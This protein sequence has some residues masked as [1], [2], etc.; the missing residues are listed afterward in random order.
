MASPISSTDI[1]LSSPVLHRPIP[2]GEYIDSYFSNADTIKSIAWKMLKILDKL[3]QLKNRQIESVVLFNMTRD[4]FEISGNPGHYSI[5]IANQKYYKVFSTIGEKENLSRVAYIVH[6]L[7]HICEGPTPPELD[8]LIVKLSSSKYSVKDALRHPFFTGQIVGIKRPLSLTP[9][10]EKLSKLTKEH[11]ALVCASGELTCFFP[12]T[13]A[14]CCKILGG[15]GSS[16]V[17]SINAWRHGAKKTHEVAVKA[18]SY[19]SGFLYEKAVADDARAQ[20]PG[21]S[22][23]LPSFPID[24]FTF[25]R[26]TKEDFLLKHLSGLEQDRYFLVS[27]L[28]A[29]DLNTLLTNNDLGLRHIHLIAKDLFSQ[30]EKLYD[31]GIIH[32]DI[33]PGNVLVFTEKIADG[34]SS[35]LGVELCDFGISYS[36]RVRQEDYC[37]PDPPTT[38]HYRAFDLCDGIPTRNVTEIHD[39]KETFVK[40]KVLSRSADMWSVG[41]TLAELVTKSPIFPGSKDSRQLKEIKEVLGLQ[42]FSDPSSE[43]GTIKASLRNLFS[44]KGNTEIKKLIRECNT[45]VENLIDLITRCFATDPERRITAKE[46]LEHPFIKGL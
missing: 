18:F 16:T 5:T 32:Y 43:A 11:F 10:E 26:K 25:T 40:R 1:N 13:M 28:A 36:P 46:A 22:D 4:T 27:D 39:G 44:K 38:R 19:R 14:A 29:C 45:D 15:R 20:C 24:S 7:R 41:A 9:L 42:D 31:A 6:S 34:K 8:N 33:K 2:L 30:L 17:Y 3:Y 23:S 35:L 37:L 21:D 12:R